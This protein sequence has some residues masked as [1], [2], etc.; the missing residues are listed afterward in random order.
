M[1]TSCSA[2]HNTLADALKSLKQAVARRLIDDADH[3]WQKRYYDFNVR[4]TLSLWKSCAIFIE[5]L[6]KAGGANVRRTGNGAVFATMQ[7]AL[8]DGSRSS[9]N[10]GHE[11]ANEVREDFVQQ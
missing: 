1:S 8:R 6:S 5:I 10:G 7:P 11:N 4:N 9:R 2:N 3:F